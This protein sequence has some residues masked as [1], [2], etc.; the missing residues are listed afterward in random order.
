MTPSGR[1]HAD[2]LDQRVN[3]WLRQRG[4]IAWYLAEQNIQPGLRTQHGEATKS[5]QNKP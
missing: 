2:R 5:R 4:K 1:V 3:Q